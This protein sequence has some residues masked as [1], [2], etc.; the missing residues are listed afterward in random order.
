QPGAEV[1]GAAAE[2]DDLLAGYL[3][4]PLDLALGKA[5]L[6]P[7]DLVL[8]PRLA[9]AGV[10]V[11]LVGARPALAVDRDV[12]RLSHRTRARSRAEPTQ[13]SPSRAR[14]CSASQAR[15]RRG[16]SREPR[17]WDSSRPS[18]FGRPRSPTRPR[19][20]ARASVPR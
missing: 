18:S 13:G 4:Q 6:A 15:D 3:G 7:G 8:S 11:L 19:G 17:P 1:A 9:S 14:G 2:L 10:G 16:S 20:Q 12:I 5:P